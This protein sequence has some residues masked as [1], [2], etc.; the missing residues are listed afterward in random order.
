MLLSTIIYSFNC[1]KNNQ[2][3]QLLLEKDDLVSKIYIK[4]FTNNSL[5]LTTTGS[6]TENTSNFSST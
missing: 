3:C 4:S 5:T 6:T 2:T 1:F